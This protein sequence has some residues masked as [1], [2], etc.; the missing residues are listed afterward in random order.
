MQSLPVSL[1]AGWS[2]VCGHISRGLTSS[3]VLLLFRTLSKILRCRRS[4]TLE[5]SELLLLPLP[6]PPPPPLPLQPRLVHQPLLHPPLRLSLRNQLSHVPLDPRVVLNRILT[7]PHPLRQLLHPRPR[8][9]RDP[10]AQLLGRPH[11]VVSGGERQ[12]ECS[13]L[14]QLGARS[15]LQPAARVR[16][17]DPCDGRLVPAPWVAERQRELGKRY[18]REAEMCG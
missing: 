13:P 16:Q 4:V 12:R 17:P 14:P 2:C 10:S 18:G 5:S 15:A 6:M 8:L 1:H 3:A 11:A 7:R 9:V